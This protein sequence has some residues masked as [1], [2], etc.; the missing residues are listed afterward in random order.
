MVGNNAT[1]NWVFDC[2]DYCVFAEG[3]SSSKE[4]MPVKPLGQNS[5]RLDLWLVVDF[6]GSSWTC[7]QVVL[8][9]LTSDYS[10]LHTSIK[11]VYCY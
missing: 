4:V 1:S 9:L 10:P 5:F 11:L 7:P 6:A 3:T 2:A 8:S